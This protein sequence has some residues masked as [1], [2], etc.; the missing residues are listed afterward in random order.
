[1]STQVVLPT[2]VTRTA[3]R[4]LTPQRGPQRLLPVRVTHRPSPPGATPA[5]TAT[6]RLLYAVDRPLPPPRPAPRPAVLRR[7]QEVG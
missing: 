4:Q 3:L 5:R 7:P 1:M 2:L 6:G